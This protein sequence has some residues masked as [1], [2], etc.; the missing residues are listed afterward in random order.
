MHRR[1]FLRGSAAVAG[2]AL[3]TTSLATRSAQG[4]SRQG[5][6][7]QLDYAPPLNMFREH[8]ADP[9]E[10][11]H[12]LAEQGFRSIEDNG[13]P[14]RPVAQQEAIRAALDE[15]GMRMGVFVASA[16]FK[17]VDF[18][19]RDPQVRGV[20]EERMRRAVEVADRV[21]AKWCTVVPGCYS[22]RDEW[23]YQT[24]AV[25]DNL[26]F[27]CD[28]VEPAGLTIVLEPLNWWTNHPGVFLTKIPQ[29][30]MICRAVDR[31][32]CKILFDIYHQQI[33]EG[34][35]IPNIDKAWDE[36]A[37]FQIGDNPGRKEP[38]TGEIHYRNVF[39]HIH[40]KGYGG[41]LG[42]EHGKS[43]PGKEGELKV[44]QAYRDCDA[45]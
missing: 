26:R 36:V 25:V 41:I 2:A 11:I 37:Y 28:I 22:Q 27:A 15:H 17:K 42:M 40:G 43:M 5:E 24:G 18:A 3:S 44:I 32:S 35:I 10:R 45:F 14:G 21:G 33:T 38:G 23:D 30:W 39:R 13:M 8:V 9:V 34:N 1:E 6:P 16:E 29:A 20:I 19:S 12:W 7:F 31:P 4:D